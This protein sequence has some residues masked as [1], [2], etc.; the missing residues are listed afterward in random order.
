MSFPKVICMGEALVDRLGPLGGDPLLSK[1][2]HDCFGGAP[3]NVACALGKLDVDV[4]FVGCLGDDSMGRDFKILMTNRGVNTEGCQKNKSSPTRVVLVRR[5]LDGER[6]F[7]GFDGDK[8]LGF[9]DQ[10]ISSKILADK[11]DILSTEAQW[12]LLGT[13]PLASKASSEAVWYVVKKALNANIRIGIDLNWRPTFWGDHLETDSGPDHSALKVIESLLAV[14][15]LLK[16]AKEEAFWF[17]Q[18]DDPKIISSS[19]A[20]NPDVLVTDGSKPIKWFLSGFSG[21]TKAIETGSVI[22]TT[23][24]G[25]AFTAGLFYKLIATESSKI[26]YKQAQEIIRFA[27]ACG[28]LVCSGMGAIDPQPT[29]KE[30]VELTRVK[31]S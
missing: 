7:G 13:I 26:D 11:W 29:L 9:A 21:E 19:L 17:F 24:A 30:V 5:D 16:L 14:G 15:S 27:T 6:S 18:T 28:A 20:N 31:S 4:A 10:M 3:A 8:G 12:L 23:G 2:V 25:D 22:D 1:P